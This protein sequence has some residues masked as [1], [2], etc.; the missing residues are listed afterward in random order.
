MEENLKIKDY[1]PKNETLDPKL[2]LNIILSY[3]NEPNN[4]INNQIKVNNLIFKKIE[5]TDYF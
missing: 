2:E 4:L 5:N 3:I 1:M